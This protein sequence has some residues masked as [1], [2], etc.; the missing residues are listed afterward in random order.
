M[1]L[2]GQRTSGRNARVVYRRT[3]PLDEIPNVRLIRG[4]SS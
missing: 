1:R 3:G 4:S 2:V